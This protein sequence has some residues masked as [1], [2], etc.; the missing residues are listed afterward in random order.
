MI[1]NKS[2]F[3]W[4]YVIPR[5][6]KFPIAYKGKLLSKEEYQEYWGKWVILDKREA[7]DALA[8][9][10]DSYVED[11]TIQGIKYSRSPEEIFGINECVMCV[12][13]DDREKEDVWK[14]LKQEGV[15][16]KA[17]VYDREVFDMWSPGGALIEKWLT[18]HD[19]TGK[20]ADG[21]REKTKLNFEKWLST[22]GKDGQNPWSFE[23][24]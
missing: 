4:I 9:S 20:E 21:I 2:F 5:N 15:K 8:K 23:M 6:W 14:I 13:C 19:I 22:I 17:W 16:I 11:R 24:M 10:L 1:V 7:L 12:F 3:Y 18:A